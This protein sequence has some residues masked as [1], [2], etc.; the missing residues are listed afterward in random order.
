MRHLHRSG[1]ARE[2]RLAIRERLDSLWHDLRYA[3]RSLRHTARFTA[4]AVL[5][6]ALGLGATTAIF[7][8]VDHIVLRPLSYADPSHL[9]VVREIIGAIRHVY[10]TMPANAGHFLEW[11]RGC[12]TCEGLA[13]VRALPVTLTPDAGDPKRVGGARVSASV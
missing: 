1:H 13:A 11:R 10:P 8:L 7:S 9:V 2:E 3:V 6:L 4:A 5:T 12:T